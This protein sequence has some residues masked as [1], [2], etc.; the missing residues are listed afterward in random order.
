MSVTEVL[1]IYI[2]CLCNANN[3]NYLHTIDTDLNNKNCV[4]L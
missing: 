3:I 1:A 2:L 4:R